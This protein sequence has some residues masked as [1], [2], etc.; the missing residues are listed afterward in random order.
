MIKNI[1]KW[2]VISYDN[3]MKFLLVTRT[4]SRKFNTIKKL[5]RKTINLERRIT[6]LRKKLDANAK[7]SAKHS[8]S[9]KTSSLTRTWNVQKKKY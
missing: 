7:S 5:K 1:W 6:V 2:N 8:H 4:C 3:K 9:R